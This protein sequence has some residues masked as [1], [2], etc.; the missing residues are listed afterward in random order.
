MQVHNFNGNYCW[1]FL[2]SYPV[3]EIFLSLASQSTK[4]CNT[5]IKHNLKCPV[6]KCFNIRIC[7]FFLL[8]H[9]LLHFCYTISPP[10]SQDIVRTYVC[11]HMVVYIVI[12]HKCLKSN[13]KTKRHL[14]SFF[15][16]PNNAVCL[17][18]IDLLFRQFLNSKLLFSSIRCVLYCS[19]KLVLCDLS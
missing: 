19:C 18:V 2:I 15:A 1:N 12:F 6:C 17:F 16:T 7:L 14:M 10:L 9:V 8:H 5:C 4:Q 13:K 11:A 3:R